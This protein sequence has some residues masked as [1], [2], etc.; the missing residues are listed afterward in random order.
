MASQ[1][2]LHINT[3]SAS[4]ELPRLLSIDPDDDDSTKITQGPVKHSRTASVDSHESAVTTPNESSSDED[5]DTMKTDPGSIILGGRGGG[6]TE[7]GSAS[8]GGYGHRN[9]EP[10]LKEPR[11]S[12]SDASIS[13]SRL[14]VS[15]DDAWKR[16]MSIPV[17]LVKDEDEPGDRY[18]ITSDDPELREILRNGAQLE[19]KDS[20]GQRRA[21][22]SDLVFTRQFTAFDRQNKSSSSSTFHGF[23]TLFWMSSALWMIKIMATQWRLYGNLLGRNEI[24]SIMASKDVIVLGL[25]DGVMVGSTFFNLLFQRAIMKGWLSWNSSGWI[26]QNVSTEPN[27]A[28]L[29]LNTNKRLGMANI[30]YWRSCGLDPLQRLALDPHRLHRTSYP[31]LPDETA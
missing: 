21:R 25:T 27:L 13:P 15:N 23:H 22:F 18:V 28:T 9:S 5:Y 30:Y 26:V 7:E 29:T 10:W 6:F 3:S 14:K 19:A 1:G 31:H 12:N 2:D 16:R 24:M 4:Q 11:L 17:K 8:A 20:K